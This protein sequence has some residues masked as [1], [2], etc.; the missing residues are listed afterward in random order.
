M[1]AN[2]HLSTKKKIIIHADLIKGLRADEAGAQFLAQVIKPAGIISTHSNVITVARKQG[3][4]SV[5]RI[6]L[7]DSHSLETSYR[8]VRNSEPDYV[9][10]LPGVIPKLIAEVLAGTQ[11]PVIAG[12]FVRTPEEAEQ[13]LK[14]GASAVSTSSHSM[15]RHPVRTAVR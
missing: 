3:L 7:L 12:G 9:E 5:H 2:L 13:V 1:C 4:I 6:F 11:T 10:V 14:A 15:W 8:I